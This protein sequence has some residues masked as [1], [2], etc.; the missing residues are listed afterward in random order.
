MSIAISRFSA[1]ACV[2]LCGVSACAQAAEYT[3]V[4]PTAST[5]SFTYDQM[6]SR[7]YGTFSKFVGTLHFDTTRPQQAQA[8]LII[9]LESIEVDDNDARAELPK[10]AWFD[11]ATHPK[12]IFESTHVKDLGNHRYLVTGRLTLRGLTRQVN[13]PVLLK[14]DNA[15]G[16]FDGEL[17]LKRSDFRIGEGEWAD[18]VVSNDINIRLRIVAPER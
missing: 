16:V 11:T 15:V 18:S 5:I 10:P 9:D 4:N 17:I 8:R 13:V 12:A 3:D 7:V 14:A 1:L 6:G 2:W